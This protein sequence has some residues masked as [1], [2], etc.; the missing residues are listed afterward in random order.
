[1]LAALIVNI[2]AIL[3]SLFSRKKDSKLLKSAFFVIFIFLAIRYGYG[4]DYMGYLKYFLEV[5]KYVYV[6][7]DYI[8][9]ILHFEVYPSLR[10]VE[11]GYIFL[12]KIFQPL[13]FFAMVATVSALYCY[14]HYKLINEYVPPLYY[15]FSVAI[16]VFNPQYVLIQASAMRQSIAIIILIVSFYYLKNRNLVGYGIGIYVSSLFHKSSMVNF[17]L[18]LLAVR[19]RSPKIIH[20]VIVA[21]IYVVTLSAT[22]YFS[23]IM[24]LILGIYFE[25]YQVYDN[26]NTGKL[27]SG[28]G[29]IYNL[30]IIT[31]ILYY[32]IKEHGDILLLNK[33]AVISLLITA[34]GSVNIMMSRIGYYYIF[35]LLVSIPY[36][37]SKTE[38]K[39]LKYGI[40]TSY[41][42]Y[43]I[44]LW[45]SHFYSPVWHDSYYEYHTIF[46]SSTI[47]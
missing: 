19:N 35:A 40:I 17:P 45:Y 39:V 10:D 29:I 20:I 32:S 3:L 37:V 25:N 23:Q 46:E 12:C 34:M 11:V 2:I 16:Y 6:F 38:N 47:Y 9:N 42:L 15:W 26:M 8:D 44:L 36:I 33:I 14:V 41:L 13:G 43:V 28:I 27:N 1:V 30:V 22:V 7:S 21:I 31:I 5:N 24:N 4:N 18:Y